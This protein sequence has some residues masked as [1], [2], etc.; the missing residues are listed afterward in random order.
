M[1]LSLTLLLLPLV[2][3][4]RAQAQPTTGRWTVDAGVS[5]LPVSVTDM[6]LF[7]GVTR[8]IAT[9]GPLE[10]GV[11][12]AA[13][14]V[15]TLHRGAVVSVLPYCPDSPRG[16]C[17]GYNDHSRM[18]LPVMAGLT[19]RLVGLPWVFNR[20]VPEFGTGGYYTQWRN[21][22]TWDAERPSVLTGYRFYAVGLR[23]TKRV[24][25][26]IG[27]RQFLNVRNRDDKTVGHAAVRVRFP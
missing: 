26:S 15:A 12:A 14:G 20:I 10:W 11:G 9:T 3:A 7:A 22:P 13:Y 17:S 8:R 5:W 27:E 23:V 16:Q 24:G 25:V 21:L 4:G 2:V 6:V 19:V 18:R 1:R